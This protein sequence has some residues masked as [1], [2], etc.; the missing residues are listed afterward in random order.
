MN[1][2]QKLKAI[3]VTLNQVPSKSSVDEMIDLLKADG[4][5]EKFIK[6]HDCTGL[7]LVVP[8]F[9]FGGRIFF[10]KHERFDDGDMIRTSIVKSVS[11]IDGEFTLV[12]TRNSRYLCIG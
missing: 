5:A 12:E 4:R 11:S 8:G 3:D 9:S 6:E 10:D 2:Y 1:L 7:I